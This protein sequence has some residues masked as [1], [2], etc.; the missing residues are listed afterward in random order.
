MEDVFLSDPR[1]TSA[2]EI[3]KKKKNSKN[4]RR[5]KHYL[6]DLIVKSLIVASLL[7]IN[8]TLF[9][10]S[11]SYN[12]FLPTG[13]ISPEAYWLYT[14]ILSTSLC[15]MFLVSFSVTLQNILVSAIA[16]LFALSMLNQFALFDINSF[17]A[18]YLGGD[19]N[20]LSN[21]FEN[22]SH[23]IVCGIIFIIVWFVFSISH[24]Q[25]QFYTLVLL[26]MIQGGLLSDAY[27]NPNIKIFEPKAYL[28]DESTHPESNNIIYIALPN[29]STFTNLKKLDPKGRNNDIKQAAE[30]IL[31][32]YLQ[33]NFTYYPNAYLHNIGLPF[34]NLS[35]SLNLNHTDSMDEILLSEIVVNGYWDFKHLKQENIYLRHNRLFDRFHK[36]DYNLRIYQGQ[37]IELCSINNNLSVNRCLQKVA[38]PINLSD[39]KLNFEQ[40][41]SLLATQWLESTGIISGIN[42]VLGIFSAFNSEVTPLRFSSKELHSFN[43]FKT[44]DIIA[45]DIITDK[46]NNFY[47]TVLDLPSELYLYD[48]LC[49]LKPLSRW[50]SSTDKSTNKNMQYSAYAEQTSCLYGK[51]ESFIRKLE[52]NQKLKNT[53]IIIEGI[54]PAFP[55]LPGIEKDLFKSLQS[56]KQAG[57]AIYNNLYPQANIDTR[58]C[59]SSSI[60]RNHFNQQN[61]CIEFEDF[62]LTDQ[63]KDEMLQ[64][65]K[66]Q[67]LDNQTTDNAKKS[68]NTW[69]QT[70]AAYNQIDITPEEQVIPL[71][72]LPQNTIVAEKEI[73]KVAVSE[74]D[75]LPQEAK[76][77]PLDAKIVN[78]SSDIENDNLPKTD[79][80][81]SST[82]TTKDISITTSSSTEKVE[83]IQKTEEVEKTLPKLDLDKPLLKPEQLKKEFKSKQSDIEKKSETVV[84]TTSSK[85]INNMKQEVNVEVKVIENTN[86]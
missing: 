18:H 1:Q 56:N 8:F 9:A 31:G 24:R 26:L 2:K 33:N 58:A 25:I 49:N 34:I 3:V 45:E 67:A 42:P 10:E 62:S 43:A 41:V 53:T 5:F 12:L 4:R 14:A 40:K 60:L 47:F 71:E 76:T 73:S 32:F 66:E 35:E 44:L 68:F 79:K 85:A 59:L 63:L 36:Q 52:Q 37:G 72:K 51:L 74:A 77:K 23:L 80:D 16:G 84:Q 48:S 69:Y 64:K 30:N 86:F 21:I 55:A 82:E 39:T 19:N 54:S 57:L 27:F 13:K 50:V 20:L 11:G 15:C 61:D 38:Y 6:F 46:G 7:A 81:S 22:F 17:L 70:W 78:T 75:E 65:A 29:A 28:N 83:N